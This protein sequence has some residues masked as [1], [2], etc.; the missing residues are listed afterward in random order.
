MIG[1]NVEPANVVAH[2]DKNIR[3]LS[4]RLRERRPRN[5]RRGRKKNRGDDTTQY[6][7]ENWASRRMRQ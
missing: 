6:A 7:L 2:D 1:A 5:F 4:G 3:L